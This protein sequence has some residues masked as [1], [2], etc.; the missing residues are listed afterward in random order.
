MLVY[1]T[2]DCSNRS[3]ISDL[4]LKLNIFPFQSG[5]QPRMMREHPHGTIWKLWGVG[6]GVEVFFLPVF[7]FTEFTLGVRTVAAANH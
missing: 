6:V 1:S 4:D 2:N 5:T 7:F 3:N